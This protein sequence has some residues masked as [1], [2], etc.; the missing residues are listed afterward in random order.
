MKKILSLLLSLLLLFGAGCSETEQKTESRVTTEITEDAIK[1]KITSHPRED[2]DVEVVPGITSTYGL[3]RVHFLDVGQGDCSFIELG[4]GQ[5]MLIDA[6]N[7]ENGDEIVKHIKDLQYSDIDYVV[8]THPHED[9]IGGMTEIIENFDIDIFY[10]PWAVSTSYTYEKL[11]IERLQ[12][13]SFIV[14]DVHI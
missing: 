1:F 12:G 4:N 9:H 2:L 5:T 3:M 14:M 6:G 7:N 8:A 11:Y 13:K 10:M